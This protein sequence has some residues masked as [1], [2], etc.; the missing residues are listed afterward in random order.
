[1]EKI[2]EDLDI[3]LSRMDI[4]I[5]E[6]KDIASDVAELMNIVGFVPENI[7]QVKDIFKR[8]CMTI[9]ANASNYKIDSLQIRALVK[10]NSGKTDI[11]SCSSDEQ[12]MDLI[13]KKEEK[14]E[15]KETY[16]FRPQTDKTSSFEKIIQNLIV[17]DPDSNPDEI[18]YW[19]EFRAI[20]SI[21]LTPPDFPEV[22]K[23]PM[24]LQSSI[25]ECYQNNPIINY[26]DQLMLKFLSAGPD[27]HN[28]YRYPTYH[29]IQ[30]VIV[31]DKDNNM[32]TFRK[33]FHGFS[34][35]GIRI[36][37]TIGHGI[38]LTTMETTLKRNFRTYGGESKFSSVMIAPAKKSPLGAI[39]H[40]QQRMK[41]IERDSDFENYIPPDIDSLVTR[42]GEIDIND[43][44][45][46]LKPEIKPENFVPNVNDIP[47]TSSPTSITEAF[48]RPTK[49]YAAL[50]TTIRK[51]DKIKDKKFTPYESMKNEP[52]N[53]FGIYLDLDCVNNT[54]EA[55]DKWETAL[56]TTVAI[57]KMDIYTLKG[58]LE[59]ILLKS[60][61]RFWQNISQSTK[62]TIIGTDNNLANIIT[63]AV[64]ALRLEFC[65]EGNIIKDAANV[66]KYSTALIRLKSL[67]LF[68][69]MKVVLII[70]AAVSRV[71]GLTLLDPKT[72]FTRK[73]QFDFILDGLAEVPSNDRVF[74]QWL[75]ALFQKVAF[76][77]RLLARGLFGV[78]SKTTSE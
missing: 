56:R 53:H 54:E 30:L 46:N 14:I 26:K 76:L 20:N 58:F 18:R 75:N 40:L 21:Y 17:Q 5:S 8:Q 13:S 61:L 41:M 65:G 60:A 70:M 63:R 44:F 3:L 36:R 15:V 1:M 59:R 38:I 68:M 16:S 55:I 19:Y 22:S 33:P 57:N 67:K 11:P 69:V 23:M 73:R 47:S 35:E 51:K 9:T 31:N 66:Q 64:E 48:N 49:G 39:M 62:Q 32:E 24:W 37:R 4:F 28:E 12:M 72:S 43:N 52:I 2:I 7:L 77:S 78:S 6:I 34:R 29:F 25:K 27:F 10:E 45:V 74:G 71:H 50:K 42:I